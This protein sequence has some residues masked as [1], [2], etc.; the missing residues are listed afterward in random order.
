MGFVDLPLLETLIVTMVLIFGA[1]MSGVMV[2]RYFLKHYSADE[3][4]PVGSLVAAL[5][6]LLAFLLA[7]TYSA[8]SNRFEERK[9]LLLDEVNAI[10]TAYLRADFIE[11]DALRTQSKSLLKNYVELRANVLEQRDNVGDIIRRSEEIQKELWSLAVDAVQANGGPVSL[12]YA[13][14]LNEV[15]DLHTSRVVVALK[16]QIH[17][18]VW[19][20]LMTVS[21]LSMFAIGFQFGYGGGKRVMLCIV[22]ALTFSLV[23]MMIEDLDRPLEGT[24]MVDNQPLA[25]L[26]K[27][28]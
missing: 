20:I 25:E 17:D 8:T 27:S 10:G 9:Q 18:T 4:P 5:F 22:L 21:V 7:L 12:S 2:G 13:T 24:I 28:M 14:A 16:Y 6:A 19:L 15:F 23:L 26:S 3:A 11:S 1:V